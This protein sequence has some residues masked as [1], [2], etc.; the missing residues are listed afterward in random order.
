MGF[1][2]EKASRAELRDIQDQRLEE[3]VTA[4][5]ENVDLYRKR[6]DEAGLSPSTIDTTALTAVPFT[7][8]ADIRDEYPDGLFTV[9]TGD[10]Q[11]VHTSSGTTGKPKIFGYTRDDLDTWSK[12]IARSLETSGFESQYT[13]LNPCK[14]GLVSGGLGWHDGLEQLGAT[15]VPSATA[16]MD[17][18]IEL[19]R[20]LTVDGLICFPSFALDLAGIIERQG[21]DP[22]ELSISTITVGGEPTS[23]EL[24]AEIAEAFDAVVTEHYGLS[25][26]FGAGIFTECEECQDGAHV[27]ED[28]FYPEIIDPRTDERVDDGEEGELVLT[29]LSKEAMPLLRYRTGDIATMTTDECA[30]GRTHARISVTERMRNGISID[31]TTVYPTE[32]ESTFLTEPETAPYYRIDL[33]RTGQHDAINITIERKQGLDVDQSELAD[34]L[35]E[36]FL[37]EL[38]LSVDE[39]TIATPG[40]IDRT[41]GTKANRVYDNRE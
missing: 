11:R 36:R 20:D 25:E 13:V 33:Q 12:I 29:S 31:D 23:Q 38:S 15:V 5:Y 22:T 10:I 21:G 37:A 41:L 9:P 17:R 7:T 19:I 27:W 16:D 6:L 1:D 2:I 35:H 30:C 32:I 24:R 26:L 3:S 34:R 14:Y 40:T 8:S 4:V 18:Q 28:H 39:I